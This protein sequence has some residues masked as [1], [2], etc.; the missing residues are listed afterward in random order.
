MFDQLVFISPVTPYHVTFW[1]KYFFAKE[2]FFQ[3]ISL[4]KNIFIKK[5]K[6]K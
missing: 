3:I 4:K 6:A 5:H 2:H 1:I